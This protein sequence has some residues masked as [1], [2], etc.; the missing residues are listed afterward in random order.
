VA[1]S[2]RLGIKKK[3][4]PRN[5]NGKKKNQETIFGNKPKGKLDPVR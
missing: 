5:K 2:K 4:I 3:L 1:Q